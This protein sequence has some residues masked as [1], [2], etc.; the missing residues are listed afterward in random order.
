MTVE[1]EQGQQAEQ[2]AGGTSALVQGGTGAEQQAAEW[3][4]PEKFAVKTESGELDYKASIQQ[5]GKSYG[6]LEKRL[7]SGDAPPATDEDYKVEGIEGFN[8]DDFKANDENKAFLKAAHAKGLNNAQLGF[9]LSEY[10]RIIPEVVSNITRMNADECNSTLQKEWG[11]SAGANYQ[12]AFRAG[13]AAGLTEEQMNDPSIGSNPAIVK[14][15]A[16]YGNQL[17]ED[18]PPSG[19][20]FSGGEDIKSLLASEAYRNPK[21]P[22]HA[23]TYA[24]VEKYYQTQA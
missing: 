21:H 17:N 8:F 3:T 11:E 13:I 24:K 18:R 14:L 6:E 12:A 1:Q 20:G 16:F 23:R 15:L 19:G 4:L 2:P 9:V 22:D 5:I 10:N 7:G